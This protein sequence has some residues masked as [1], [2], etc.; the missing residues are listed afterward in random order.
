MIFRDSDGLG[1]IGDGDLLSR[2]SVP[3][4]WDD[5]GHVGESGERIGC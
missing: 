4:I 3:G 2:G 1:D 5:R